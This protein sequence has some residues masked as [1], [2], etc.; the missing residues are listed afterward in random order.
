MGKKQDRSLVYSVHMGFLKRRASDCKVLSNAGFTL[1]EVIMVLIVASI[2]G[3]L[4]VQFMGTSLIRSGNPVIMV[5]SE[6]S[7]NNVMERMT[8]DYKKLVAEDAS[9]LATF[10]TRV[11]NGNVSTNNP[12]Y[13]EYIVATKYITFDGNKVENT[14]SSGDKVLKVTISDRGQKLVALFTK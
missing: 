9:P 6:F 4:L 5:Q 11:Q 10:K 12:Y 8:A 1:L 13:G 7:L 14:N 3:A 2:L